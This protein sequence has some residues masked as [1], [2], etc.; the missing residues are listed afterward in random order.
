MLPAP[1]AEGASPG[2]LGKIAHASTERI[3][4]LKQQ[5]LD[6]G[7]Q[8]KQQAATTYR[9]VDPTPLAAA[10]PGAVGAVIASCLAIGGGAAT[11]CVQQGVDP[12]GAATGLIASES[13]GEPEP[14]SAAPPEAESTGPEYTPAETPVEEAPAPEPTPEP[15]ASKPKQEQQPQAESPP[16]EDS[17]EPVAPSYT[18]SEAEPEAAYEPPPAE[19]APRPGE[20]LA[21]IRGSVMRL[22]PRDLRGAA[23][24][25]GV[26][27]IL[28]GLATPRPAVAGEYTIQACQA[29]DAGYVSSAFQD[30]ATRGMKWRRACNPLGPGLRG[31]VSA[32]VPG[33]GKVARGAQ[34]GFELD[35]PPGTTSLASAGQAT[36]SGVI[37]ATPFSSMP[38]APAPRRSRFGMSAPTTTAPAPTWPRRRAG[39]ACAPTT[40]A[41]R[42][43]SS[44]GSSAS[45]PPRASSARPE[46]RTSYAPSRPKRPWW[47][48]PLHRRGSPRARRLP[49][50]SG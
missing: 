39:R 13:E 45:A 5:V 29:D 32:N 7:A 40:S 6:G 20:L 46:V 49:W 27:A 35:A 48:A 18:E 33:T 12:I 16:P 11:Y 3:A 10:R 28:A 2:L 43:G 37:A 15:A 34:S 14:E 4:A 41:A 50:G 22:A 44:S 31:L 42:L 36:R 21:S 38:S 26:V 17:F 8:V 9:A 19:P 1:V 47:M 24:I 25:A 30:F 23:A